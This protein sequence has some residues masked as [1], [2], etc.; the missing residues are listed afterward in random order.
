MSAAFYIVFDSP[1]PGFEPFVNG[2]ALSRASEAVEAAAVKA[3]V[4]PLMSFFSISPDD[5]AALAEESGADMGDA[6]IPSEA[7]FSADDG[8]RTV[9]ALLGALET[10][11]ASLGEG[12]REDLL[13]FE[14]V[15]RQAK[16][17]GLR[18]HLGIDY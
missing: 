1:E 14:A 18:W 3:G 11:P 4:A 7:W 13:E 17:R 9:A 15:L 8:L 2:K 12:V 5:A 10:D 16:G 6:D